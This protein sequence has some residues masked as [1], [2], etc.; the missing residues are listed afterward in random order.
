MIGDTTQALVFY[1]KT[2]KKDGKYVKAISNLS[3][4]LDAKGE[5]DTFFKLN[6]KILQLAP[7]SDVPYINISNHYLLTGDTVKSIEYMEL[8]FEKAPNNTGLIQ[9][10]I[11]YYQSKGNIQKVD[12]YSEKLKM[13]KK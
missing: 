5:T 13:L 1:K 2:L 12:Y 10:L 8:A 3:K 9:N 6:K 4:L 7:L 11:N